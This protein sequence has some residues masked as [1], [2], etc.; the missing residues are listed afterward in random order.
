MHVEVLIIDEETLSYGRVTVIKSVNIEPKV[1]KAKISLTKQV[2]Y[3][4][5]SASNWQSLLAM[6]CC[7]SVKIAARCQSAS[8]ESSADS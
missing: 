4:S 8:P 6:T 3:S 2:T 1:M 7:E 5:S